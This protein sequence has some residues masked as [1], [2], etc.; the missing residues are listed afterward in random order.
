MKKT[1]EQLSQRSLK[2]PPPMDVEAEQSVLSALLIAPERI[3][4]VLTI[5]QPDD[6]SKPSHRHILAAIQQTYTGDGV[7]L[8]TIRDALQRQH[9][10]DEVGGPA[11]LAALVDAVPTATNVMAHA[12]IVH[13]KAMARKL[14][15]NAVELATR[16]YDDSETAAALIKEAKDRFESLWRLMHNETARTFWTQDAVGRAARLETDRLLRYL[17][18]AG[19][20]M[21]EINDAVLFVHNRDNILQETVWVKS[22]NKTIK[23]HLK[24]YLL[25]EIDRRDVWSLLADK[26]RLVSSAILTGLDTLQGEFYR[27]TPE[28]C[29][30]F[31]RNGVLQISAARVDWRPYSD[32]MGYVWKDQ[33]SPHDY[34][35]IYNGQT[36]WPQIRADL[37]R[38]LKA[39]D[40]LRANVL[41]R[42]ISA[43]QHLRRTQ[44]VV[45]DHDIYQIILT[46]SDETGEAMR[47]AAQA[48]RTD[49]VRQGDRELSI[50]LGDYYKQHDD[51]QRS[52]YQRFLELVSQERVEEYDGKTLTVNNLHGF[53]FAIAYLL[54]GYNHKA[55]MR[56]VILADSNPSFV[57]NGRRGKGV[58]L[59]ALKHLKGEIVIKEDGKAFNN[60]QFK[61]QLVR[62]NTRVLILDDVAED[63]DFSMLF[64]AITDAFVVESKGFK[65]IAFTFADT[66]RFVITTNHP[67]DDEGVSSSERTILLPVADY[68]TAHGLTPYQ[69]FGH[70]LFDDWDQA[71]WDRFFDYIVDIVQRYLQR[72][73]PSVIPVIDHSIFNANKLLL[74]VPEPMVNYLDK[75]QK[76]HDYERDEVVRDVE[77]L[78]IKFRT[79]NEFSRLLHTYARLRGYHLKRNTK[80]GRYISNGVQY[81][82]FYSKTPDMFEAAYRRAK[83]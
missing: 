38:S 21:L 79:S 51:R 8:L 56:A 43:V 7:N 1:Y 57:S 30:L 62:P 23:D 40:R 35:G 3:P 66:P 72:A 13:E 42:I 50:L 34:T 58:I 6:L 14:L 20:Y 39:R 63:F 70:M 15:T 52:E 11:Y 37:H 78:G 82:R 4:D 5:M 46:L 64:S 55:N 9:V 31:F 22:V 61:F 60:G 83:E 67:C 36:L 2:T 45:S 59:Q 29:C 81:I 10:L 44:S 24:T 73:D 71:E 74:K 28:Q 26:P 47:Y 33:I 76:D 65:R 25:D 17:H 12:R 19:Y 54:H 16:A 18:Q 68:F 53:E 77:G 48:K 69:V 27:D 32:I 80:D 41:R 49:L 75:L